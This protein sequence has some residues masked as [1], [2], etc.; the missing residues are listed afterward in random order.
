MLSYSIDDFSIMNQII[1]KFEIIQSIEWSV[2][3]L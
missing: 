2:I 3:A 1:Q